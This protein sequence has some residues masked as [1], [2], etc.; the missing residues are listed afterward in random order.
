MDKGPD[1]GPDEGPKG[2]KGE[3]EKEEGT[4]VF[5]LVRSVG[6]EVGAECKAPPAQKVMLPGIFRFNQKNPNVARLKG[7]FDRM[8]VARRQVVGSRKSAS[9]KRKGRG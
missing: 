7:L 8:E 2:D 9:A 1:E 4:G 5:P 3:G 6:E